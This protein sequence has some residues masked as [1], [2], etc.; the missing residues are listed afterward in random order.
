MFLGLFFAELIARRSN[1]KSQ[2]HGYPAIR[3]R[4][5][6]GSQPAISG[7][8]AKVGSLLYTKISVGNTLSRKKKSSPR[9]DSIIPVSHDGIGPAATTAVHFFLN[10]R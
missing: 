7:E 6:Q 3:E 1:L 9:W 4:T 5:S 8:T 2:H 10:K